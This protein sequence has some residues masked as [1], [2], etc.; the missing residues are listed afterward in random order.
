MSDGAR[1]KT[2]PV[3]VER[4]HRPRQVCFAE[5]GQVIVSGSDHGTIYL[6]DRRTGDQLD[7]LALGN[8]DWAQTVMVSRSHVS[9]QSMVS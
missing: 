3:P 2:F 6:Y 9:S 8:N 4:S 5:D 7:E 1:L